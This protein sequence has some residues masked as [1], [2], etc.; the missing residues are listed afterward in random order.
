VAVIS[1]TVLVGGGNSGE[2][3]DLRL[4]NRAPGYSIAWCVKESG[5][6][7]EVEYRS[8]LTSSLLLIY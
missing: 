8:P 1:G 7:W 6:L 2:R 4:Y 3:E 5:V